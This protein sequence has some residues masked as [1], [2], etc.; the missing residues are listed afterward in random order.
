MCPELALQLQA[1]ARSYVPKGERRYKKEEKGGEKNNY[2]YLS[3]RDARGVNTRAA[4]P[5]DGCI[6]CIK[7]L[8]DS[9][10]FYSRDVGQCRRQ[11]GHLL[12]TRYKRSPWHI[13]HGMIRHIIVEINIAVLNL[14]IS[15]KNNT[16][17]RI[18]TYS[19][20]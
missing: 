13:A 17:T 3:E 4:E 2:N 8:R 1:T 5:G 15:R 19:R 20:A 9:T 12:T 16:H 14:T 10:F 18:C 7:L 11:V 6:R